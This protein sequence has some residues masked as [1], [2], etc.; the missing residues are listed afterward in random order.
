MKRL[1]ASVV[2][3]LFSVSTTPAQD[4]AVEYQVKAAFLFNFA[5]FV[6]WPSR[7]FPATN[8]AF[9]IC[10]AGDPFR[11]AVEKTIQ[12]ERWNGRP[13]AVKRIDSASS[14]PG[15]HIVYVSRS[16][17]RDMEILMAAANAPVLTVGEAADFITAGGIIRFTA[18]GRRIRFEINPEAAERV[19]LRV[20]SRLLRLA[21]IVRPQRAG[22]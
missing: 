5:K 17:P 21:D 6:E 11:G 10:L 1:L 7:A 15:C 2:G 3:I 9:N 4:A 8:S 16:V 12:G 13:L 19:S 18:S 22:N 20:S 14:V